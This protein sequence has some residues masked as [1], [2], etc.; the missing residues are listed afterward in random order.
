MKNLQTF[1]TTQPLKDSPRNILPDP[2][3]NYNVQMIGNQVK[4]QS[5][6]STVKYGAGTPDGQRQMVGSQVTL[7]SKPMSGWQSYPTPPSERTVA[8]KK[9]F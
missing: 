3:K 8:S 7:N 9:N 5:E 6:P 1:A 2:G 4:L